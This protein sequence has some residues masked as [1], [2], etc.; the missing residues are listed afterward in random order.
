MSSV[1]RSGS[2]RAK[3]GEHDGTPQCGEKGPPERRS[4]QGNA[5]KCALCASHGTEGTVGVVVAVESPRK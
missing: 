1:I 3:G 4:S 2:E 5:E